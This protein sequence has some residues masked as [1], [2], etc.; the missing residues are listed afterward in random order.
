[1]KF[2]DSFVGGGGGESLDKLVKNLCD[3]ADK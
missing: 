3:K 2:I 1:M